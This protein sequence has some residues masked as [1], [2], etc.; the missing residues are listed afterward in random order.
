M[1]QEDRVQQIRGQWAE[2]NIMVENFLDSFA[3]L[4]P[5]PQEVNDHPQLQID[6]P[7]QGEIDVPG[8]DQQFEEEQHDNVQ[9]EHQQHDNVQ[10]E[11]QQ[12]GDRD[13]VTWTRGN[14]GK[15]VEGEWIQC[16]RLHSSRQ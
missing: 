16:S 11:H 5:E 4:Q 13:I 9:F 10:P 14:C 2:I 7:Q 12:E 15:A 1:E 6:D 8:G 3:Q